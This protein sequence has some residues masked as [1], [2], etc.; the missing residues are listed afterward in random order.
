VFRNR[1]NRRRAARA[2]NSRL[3]TMQERVQDGGQRAAE[4]IGPAA[5]QARTAAAY[6]LGGARV[7]A[8]ERVVDARAAAAPRIVR[9]ADYVQHDLGPRVGSML[10]TAGHKLEPPRRRRRGSILMVLVMLGGL[11]GAIG[12]MVARRNSERTAFEDTDSE[13]AGDSPGEMAAAR[14][15]AASSDGQL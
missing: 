1:R 3:H 11:V 12:A 5:Q 15:S 7:W 10:K 4:K 9:A 13:E 8:G 6:R 2:K 14:Q